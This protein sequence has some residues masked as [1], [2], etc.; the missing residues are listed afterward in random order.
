VL[1]ILIPTKPAK[2][3]HSTCPKSIKY[4]TAGCSLLSFLD[5][6]SRYHQILL[7]IEDQIKTSF[8]TLFDAFCYTTMLF[9]LKSVGT[10]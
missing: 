3:I 5:C 7:N 10:M 4:S 1:I 8:I 2:K 6:Y 9:R